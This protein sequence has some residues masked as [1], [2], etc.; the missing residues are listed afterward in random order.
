MITLGIYPITNAISGDRRGSVGNSAVLT[1]LGMLELV[2][3]IP[4]LS[5]MSVCISDLTTSV[6]F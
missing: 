3:Q 2:V 1:P 4:L 5:G 6:E